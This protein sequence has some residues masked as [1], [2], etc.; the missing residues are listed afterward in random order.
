LAP[1]PTIVDKDR[2]VAL[3]RGE[4]AA[5]R[6]LAAT[7][8][9]EQ[10]EVATC[11]PGWTVRDVVAHVI[12]TESM[13]CGEQAPAVDVSRLDHVRNPIAEANER[14]VESMR[15]CSGEEMQARLADVTDRRLAALDAM[16]QEAFDAPSWTPVGNDETYGRFMRIRHFDCFMHENDVRAAVGTGLREDVDD[17][18]SSLDEIET[19]LGY[20]VGRRAA[21]PD[22]TRV[23]IVLT[24]PVRTTY[25]VA[26]DGRAAVVPSL[27]GPP[28]VGIE[29]PASAFV[30]LTGGRDDGTTPAGAVHL[31]GDRALAE[32][33]VANLAFTI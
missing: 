33:L 28:T 10:W 6:T 29:L 11:L 31:S 15:R 17:L 3:L 9:A 22:G 4:F 26:V 21:L 32:R 12:G 24:G 30:R 19:G 13:L 2:T 23:A 18:R 7:L 16:T 5:L 14:W 20:I 1:V 25:F 27:D 8:D